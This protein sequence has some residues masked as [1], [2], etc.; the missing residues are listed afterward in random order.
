MNKAKEGEWSTSSDPIFLSPTS[1][2]RRAL[3]GCSSLRA[4]GLS[5]C[6]LVLAGP[7]C[8]GD[9]EVL[10]GIF[11]SM[12]RDLIA[13]QPTSRAVRAPGVFPLKEGKLYA[14]REALRSSTFEECTTNQDFIQRWS[15]DAWIYIAMMGCNILAGHPAALGLGRWNWLE[16]EAASAVKM[17]IQRRLESDVSI[18]PDAVGM[19]EELKNRHI[20]YA[21][22]E[23]SKCHPLSLKQILPSLPPKSHGGS[24]DSLDWLGPR[25]KEFLLHPERCLLPEDTFEPLALPGRVHIVSEDRLAIAQELVSRNI[26][27]WIDLEEVHVVQGRKLLNGMFGVTKPSTTDEG[28][29]VLRVIMNLIP[30]NKITH[31]LPGA[32]DSLPAITAWQS[33][34]LDGEES[35]AVWQS[36]MSSA[37]YLFKIPEQWGKFL[38]FNIVLS[39]AEVGFPGI[40]K[41]A[42]CSNVIPMGWSSSVGLMQEMA[43]ALAYAGGLDRKTQVRK[44]TPL[45][46]W[47]NQVLAN[48]DT[49]DRVWWHVYLDN[50]CAGERLFPDNPGEQGQRCH[51]L[52]ENAWTAAGVLSSEKKRKRAVKVAEELGAEVNGVS[53]TIGSSSSRLLKVL[54]LTLLLLSKPFIRRKDLQILLGRWVFILQFRRP[55]MSLLHEVWSLTSGQ[56]KKK[57]AS[58]IGCRRELF[59]L[60]FLAPLF[61][62]F[63]G[64]NISPV[65]SASDASTTGGACAI[66]KQ[67]TA[68]GWDFF[69]AASVQDQNHRVCPILLIS[70]FNGI[71]GCFR[72]YDV[73]GVSVM[74]RI[75]VEINKHANRIVAKAWPGTELVWDV[76]EVDR[77]MVHEWALKYPNIEEIHL[78]AGFPC[79]D[80]SAVR[81]NRKNLEGPSSGLFWHIPRIKL[82]LKETFGSS[83]TIK[84]VIENVS[85]MDRSA[86]EEI[87]EVLETEPYKVDCVDA[88][89]MHRPR[90]CWT[91]EDISQAI[92]DIHI[93]QCSY[94]WE[95]TARSSYPLTETWI[96]PGYDWKGEKE[97]AVFPTCMKSIKR[98]KPP[99]RPAGLEKCDEGTIK[100]W[101]SDCYRFPPYQYANRYLITKGDCW[102]LLSPVE[103]E[104]LLGYGV[105]HTRACMSASEQKQNG[106]AYYDM[107]LS[108]LGDSFSIFS[109]V[110]FAVACS[111]KYLPRMSYSL[112]AQRMGLAPGFRSSYRTT[113]PISRTPQYG[114]NLDPIPADAVS[115][116]NRFLLRRT[117][118]TGSDV[119]VVS[120]QLMNP[121]N[122]PRQSVNSL[123]WKWEPTFQ[124]RWKHAEHINCLELEAI[125]LSIKHCITHL[126]L[127]TSKLFHV[128]DSYVCMS[129]IA[130]GRTSSRMLARKLR[131]LSAYLLLFDL[132]LVICHVDSGDN[133]TDAAS[134]A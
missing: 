35:I 13:K 40:K 42:L 58:V 64:A 106:D 70:L 51:E 7:F 107:R 134:R 3:D 94:W 97:G 79:V 110:I 32:V 20:G 126:H 73:A 54:Q 123:W 102:R 52:A 25:S 49:E 4:V 33:T 11:S 98:A 44:G 122:F 82:L 12:A 10:K 77:R 133:P 66:S 17:A 55:G 101:K 36:D 6:W 41:V 131:V 2:F 1:C 111:R 45:P 103:R 125:L 27:R 71:G 81:F 19:D 108:M 89:P 39:G 75:A 48:A 115:L 114:C 119:R 121:K 130:K 15:E 91:H 68:V 104:L 129:I 46:N 8:K 56:L 60:M 63:M 72:C 124:V 69:R 62:T 80:L 50:F 83:V 47:M 61:H 18:T 113:A 21:G 86:T 112:L 16:S 31:Q 84:Q 43:E 87:S 100:R 120:G 116:V 37:F 90:Y 38:S 74:G 22:E 14:V 28:L 117:N 109:F 78:W 29:P 96:Q 95:V 5:L 23:V 99:P 105:G 128:T 53:K 59:G 57:G 88:V 34:V 24:I 93:S 65:I 76:H 132:H 26:C 118:H 85:S 92:D 30:I 67:L 9:D 127:R